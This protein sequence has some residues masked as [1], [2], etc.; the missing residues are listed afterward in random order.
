MLINVPFYSNTPDDTHCFQTALRMVLKYFL[1]AQ[2][3]TWDELD[4]LTAKRAGLWTWPLAGL[5][6]LQ[7]MGFC[8]AHI[9]SFDYDRF[10]KCG[11]HYIYAMYGREAGDAQVRHSDIMQEREL[12]KVFVDKI[13][14]ERRIPQ[15]D[16]VIDLMNK[17][18]IVICNINAR[19]LNERKGYSGHFVVLI[20]Y[21]AD[22]VILHDPGLPP[23][24]NRVVSKNTFMRAWEYPDAKVK[25]VMGF[26][27]AS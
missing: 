27:Y 20:G 17:G 21:S 26:K 6:E 1:P 12:A 19:M 22:T 18:F 5:M 24:E 9:E 14:T 15:L 8:V 11:E 2:E 3:Y 23:I 25:N 4:Q 10:I 13:S 7:S 16:D